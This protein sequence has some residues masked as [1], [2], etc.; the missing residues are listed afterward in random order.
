MSK[1]SMLYQIK[2]YIRADRYI[3][4]GNIPADSIEARDAGWEF[5][6]EDEFKGGL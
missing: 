6:K 4:V 5:V 1:A 3:L 2:T